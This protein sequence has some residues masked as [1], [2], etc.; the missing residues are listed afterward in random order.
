[1]SEGKETIMATTKVPVDHSA[2]SGAQPKNGD[3]P[4]EGGFLE[5][6]GTALKKEGVDVPEAKSGTA[7]TEA[8]P[9][10]TKGVLTNIRKARSFAPPRVLLV[11]TEGIGKSTWA[12]KA[13]S[14]I[15]LP[16][17]D[18]LDSIDCETFTW[19]DGKRKRAK[20]F[21]E[22]REALTG[23]A[24]EPHSFR[25]V[26]IDSADW[27]E[28][29]ILAN[30]CRRFGKKNIEDIGYAKGYTYALDEWTETLDLLTK[31]RTRGMCV[32]LNAH[33]KIERF[34][35]PENP[36]YDR[37]S[38]RLHKHAQALLTEWVDA[39]LFATRK[40]TTKREDDTDKTSRQLAVPVGKDGGERILRTVGGP[41]CVAKNRYDL[42][43][44]LP[45][46]WGAFA[47]GLK[48]F[49]IRTA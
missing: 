37:Y 5:S 43:P 26:V 32:I 6:L 14:P 1:V 21:Q 39:V 11:G 47:D 48:A 38:P 25:T 45:L 10:T 16:T 24:N 31:C 19:E 17:E 36:S 22:V 28:K 20:D 7:Q 46:S 40:M 18:G 15:F 34:E 41:A 49:M 42:P 29:L 33:A 4:A 9:A 8:A 2:L 35:D 27:L 44:E 13:P 12:S 23:L 3:K 30:V